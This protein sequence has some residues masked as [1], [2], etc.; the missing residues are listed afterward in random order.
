[1]Q[2]K[3]FT[4]PLMDDGAYDYQKSLLEK[5][6]TLLKTKDPMKKLILYNS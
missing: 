1:M 5:T 4:V 6:K 3:I 2:I